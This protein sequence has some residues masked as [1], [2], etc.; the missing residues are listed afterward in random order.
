MP[1]EVIGRGRLEALS[2][3]LFAIVITLLVLEIRV[4]P[5][6]HGAS[7]GA[8]AEALMELV[9]KFASWVISFVTVCVIWVNHHRLF[10]A[11]GSVTHGVFWLNANLLLWISFIP[12][13]TALMGDLPASAPAVS[14]YGV[15]M[16]LMAFGFVLLRWYLQTN[17][18]LL[19]PGVD[20]AAFRRGTW[21]SVAAGPLA[22]FG[23]AGLAWLSRNGAFLCYA[24]V[25]FYFVLPHATR[26]GTPSR[27]R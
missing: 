14:L 12:F 9:P 4:P 25:A 3:G 10:A 7:D 15:V 26:T 18:D 1:V 22:Y 21:F 23:A 20:L 8:V 27:R 24:A 6:D 5:L 16:G 13:P 11:I 17:R 2:D 19:Q